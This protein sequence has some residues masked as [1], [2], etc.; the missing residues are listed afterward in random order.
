MRKFMPVPGLWG[1]H[2]KPLVERV[3]KYVGWICMRRQARLVFELAE[4]HPEISG[5]DA[6]ALCF[7]GMGVARGSYAQSRYVR[8]LDALLERRLQR[9]K[10]QALR[11]LRGETDG[12][13]RVHDP[14][15]QACPYCRSELAL[16]RETGRTLRGACIA[17]E[18]EWSCGTRREEVMREVHLRRTDRCM[19]DAQFI[20]INGPGTGGGA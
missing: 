4:H 18:T 19:A 1:G 9:D 7:S 3:R 2:R 17:I 10:R 12:N 6:L 15:P 5:R 20:N 14:A 11:E 8:M 16:Y 13:A